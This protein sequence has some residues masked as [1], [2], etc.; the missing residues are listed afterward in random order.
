[1]AN[2]LGEDLTARVVI[3]GA[4]HL[5]SNLNS[6]E[7][8]AFRVSGGFGAKSHTSGSALMGQFLFDGERCRMEG[9]MVERFATDDEIK[10]AKAMV[11]E[12]PS[13]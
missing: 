1:M 3:I 13:G 6:P 4:K 9:W 8:R 7:R 10:D 11:E 2:H 12:G 5:V